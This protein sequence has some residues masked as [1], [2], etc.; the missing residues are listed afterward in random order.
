MVDLNKGQYEKVL[1]DLCN[2]IWTEE[3]LLGGKGWF[4]NE[5][6]RKGD[7]SQ[8]NN[9]LGMMSLDLTTDKSVL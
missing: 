4:V 5:A 6:L 7:L 1:L 9:G 8:C 2:F 3:K